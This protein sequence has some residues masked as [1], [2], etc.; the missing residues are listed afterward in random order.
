MDLHRSPRNA[1]QKVCDKLCSEVMAEDGAGASADWHGGDSGPFVGCFRDNSRWKRGLGEQER[2]IQLRLQP[3]TDS[4]MTNAM[5]ANLVFVEDKKGWRS[6]HVF[7]WM[8]GR[9]KLG[10]IGPFSDICIPR[11]NLGDRRSIHR[12][13]M[14]LFVRTCDHDPSTCI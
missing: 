7:R 12:L 2:V 9:G 4:L 1:R 5:Q 10:T 3:G 14:C 11:R 13:G 8:L 6:R